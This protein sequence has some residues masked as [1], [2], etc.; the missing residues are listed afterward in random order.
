MDELV[1]N[2]DRQRSRCCL[3]SA[4]TLEEWAVEMAARG[5]ENRAVEREAR[6]ASSEQDAAVR[7][8]EYCN[9][10]GFGGA[11]GM[12]WRGDYTGVSA[13]CGRTGAAC[14]MSYLQVARALRATAHQTRLF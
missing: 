4:A 7:V 9:N 3:G 11:C 12:D 1:Q 5:V 6:A 14:R 13:R 10:S 2:C 8:R